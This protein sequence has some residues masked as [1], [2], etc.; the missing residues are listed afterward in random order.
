ML[1]LLQ[2]ICC[3]QKIRSLGNVTWFNLLPANTHF[4]LLI[5]ILTKKT[6]IS[7][8]LGKH[9]SFPFSRLSY[10]FS[11]FLLS[12]PLFLPC[13]KLVPPNSFS[14]AMGCAG[15]WGHLWKCF[16]LPIL[17]YSLLSS[18]A[19]YLFSSALAWVIHGLQSL[20]VVPAP[21][22]VICELHPFRDMP[23]LGQSTS[24]HDRVTGTVPLPPASSPASCPVSFRACS[25]SLPLLV[26][27]TPF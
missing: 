7:K 14:E 16:F 2:E 6:H 25:L 18:P 22:W 19:P 3:G 17:A 23:P 24:F 13:V 20:R 9:P 12:T 21:A 4:K 26:A 8:H 15:G 11:P 1:T 10:L 5:C 27:I